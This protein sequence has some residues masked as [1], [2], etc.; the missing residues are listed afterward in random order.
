MVVAHQDEKSKQYILWLP[1]EIHYWILSILRNDMSVSLLGRIFW[2]DGSPLMYEIQCLRFVRTTYHSPT[3]NFAHTLH[4]LFLAILTINDFWLP[5]QHKLFTIYHAQTELF[6]RYEWNKF[7]KYNLVN[8]SLQKI[9][10]PHMLNTCGTVS[11]L[12]RFIRRLV[13]LIQMYDFISWCLCLLQARK[14]FSNF[15]T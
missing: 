7:L 15:A 3:Q 5:K 13:S 8:F 1:G 9:N 2:H 10:T 12:V 11:C 14:N 4:T 6:I